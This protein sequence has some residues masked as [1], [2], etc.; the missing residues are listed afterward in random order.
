MKK[1]KM[2]LRSL[3]HAL[4]AFCFSMILWPGTAAAQNGGQIEGRVMSSKGISVAG[5]GITIANSTQKAVTDK[6][7]RYIL[8]NVPEGNLEIAASYGK[9]MVKK[10]ITVD[11][12]SVLTLDFVLEVAND[13]IESVHVSAN[14]RNV[15]SST[16]RLSENL[17]VT[18]QN[19]VVIDKGL[20]NDQ[21]IF[22]TAEGF[23]RN[24]SGARTIYHQEEASAG[25]AVRGYSASNLRNGMDV[26]GS[27]G[28]LREDMAFVDRIEFVKGPAGF[29]MG[30]TQPGGFYNIVTKKP[31]GE[32]AVNTARLSLG[33]FGLYR[34]EV[35]VDG[36]LSQDGKLLG[37]FSVMGTKKGSHVMHASNEQFVINPS[38]KY[39]HSEKTDFTAEYILS[40]NAFTGGFSKYAYGINGFKELPREFSFSDPIIDPTVVREHN[41][42]GT[43]NHYFSDNWMMTGQFGYINSQMQGESLYAT[44]NSLDQEGNVRRNLAAGDAMNTST[45]GQIFMKGKFDIGEVQNNVLMGLDMGTKFYVADWSSIDTLD[46]TFNIYNPVYGQLRKADIPTYD[47]SQSLRERGALYL[48]EYSYYSLH[49]Q[50][51]AHFLNDKLRIGAGLRYTTTMRTSAAS[52]GARVHNSALTPRFSVTGLITPTFTAFALYDQTF[53]EQTGTQVNGNP[54]D[55]ARGISKELGLKK[56]WFNGNLLAGITAYHLVRTNITTTAGPDRPGLVEQSGEATSKGI[57]VDVN[58]R[59]SPSFSVM[60]NYAYTDARISKDNNPDR[61]GMML[62]GNAEHVTN[63][64]LNYNL[65]GGALEGLGF[66]AGYEYQAKR[67]AWPSIAAGKYLPDDL[68]TVDLGASFKRDNY[69]IAVVVNNVLDRYNYTGFLPGAWGY[70][71]YGWRA[72][73]PRGFRMTLGYT[74]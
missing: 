56:T 31:K 49:L 41:V 62:Y 3:Q 29:M 7:G 11:A 26:S 67:A 12:G 44:F 35:D 6:T 72:L 22:S 1:Y 37:R 51:E 71:H 15:P 13:E 19:I 10:S 70:S 59:I 65:V 28:P 23:T 42:Y 53:Q 45:V 57:E 68:F 2:A 17:L 73:P 36:K 27:F 30:N 46:G 39:V 38:I 69:S 24:V 58:G 60:F 55:P 50:D 54:V 25:I 14:R 8:K 74:F 21:M 47:R 66:S 34:A 4:I 52:K 64:W 9:T 48:T 40:Q 33:S 18:P 63:A 20:L 43:V 16:L 5:V 61:I 32:D